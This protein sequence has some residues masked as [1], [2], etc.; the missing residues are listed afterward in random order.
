MLKFTI[1]KFILLIPKLLIITLIIFLALQA[2]PGDPITRSISPDAYAHMSDAQLD[3]MRES[4]GL[5][6]PVLIQYF[7]WMG[8][9][10]Q[11]NFGYSQSPA[12]T[13]AR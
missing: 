4:L 2:L 13:L 10:L 8:D 1:R 3:A 7:S 11:G 12:P 5:N 9:M 6:R